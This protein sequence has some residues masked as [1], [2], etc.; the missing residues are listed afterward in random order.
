MVYDTKITTE[1]F[2]KPPAS[3]S[4]NLAVLFALN[5]QISTKFKTNKKQNCRGPKNLFRLIFAP[6]KTYS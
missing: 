6:F 3:G 2:T 4:P 1:N 5:E